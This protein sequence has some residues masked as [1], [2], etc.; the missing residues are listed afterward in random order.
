MV[1]VVVT[2]RGR[3]L[4]SWTQTEWEVMEREIDLEMR[5]SAPGADERVGVADERDRTANHWV[6]DEKTHASEVQADEVG[7]VDLR[8]PPCPTCRP[9][10]RPRCASRLRSARA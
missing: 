3:R 4:L 10:P 9:D 1:R 2:Q 8:D 5:S 6:I 7:V